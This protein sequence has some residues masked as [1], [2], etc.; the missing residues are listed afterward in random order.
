[1]LYWPLPGEAEA[2]S[3][4]EQPR[5]GI[6]RTG[7]SARCAT[8]RGEQL[9]SRPHLKHIGLI[10]LPCLRKLRPQGVLKAKSIHYAQS[11]KLQFPLG[12]DTLGARTG[13]FHYP[14]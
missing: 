6:A 14:I 2:G 7:S 10:A 1:M 5:Q 4:G 11:A 8:G 13:I 9:T 12:Q 3:A